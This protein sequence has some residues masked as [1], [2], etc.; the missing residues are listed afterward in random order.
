M[1][2]VCFDYDHLPPCDGT[3]E[4]KY[5]IL[6]QKRYG[7]ADFLHVWHLGRWSNHH[8]LS[9][10]PHILPHIRG[11]NT[12]ICSTCDMVPDID[13]YDLYLYPCIFLSYI[14]C[15]NCLEFVK[16]RSRKSK[17]RNYRYLTFKVAIRLLFLLAYRAYL[18]HKQ[19]YIFVSC[20]SKA[21]F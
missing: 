13:N 20:D 4:L 9:P 17:T 3:C 7:L 19:T 10:H 1:L 14:I 5:N 15:Q 11:L 16:W 21:P 12:Y 8:I 6:L 2:E 18:L